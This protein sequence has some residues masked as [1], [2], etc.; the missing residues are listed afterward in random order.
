MRLLWYAGASTGLATG[1]IAYAFNQ[2]ANFYSAMVYLSQNNLSLMILVN[3]VLLVYA[4][5]V[6]GLQRLCY[7]PLRPVEIEQLYEKAWFAV[8]ETCLAMTIFREEVGGWFLVMFTALVTGKVWEWIGEGRV[9]VLEQQPPANPR[10]F[11]LRLSV[12]LLLSVAYDTWLFSYAVH[13]VIQQARPNMMVMFLFEFAILATCSTRTT[14]R[15]LL[16]LIE[17]D[18]T[19]KQTHTRLEERRRLVREQRNDILRR[20]ES[21]DSAEA[22][23]ARQEELPDEDDIDEMDIEVPG[24]ESKGHWILSLDLFTDL[25]KLVIYSVFFAI[26][27]MFYGLPIHIMRDLF[28]T[29]RSFVKRLGALMRYRKALQDMNKYPDATQEDLS[30]EDTCI[31]CREDMRPWDPTAVG[32]VERSRPK[33]LPCGHILH[34]GCLK[35][36]LERQQVCPTCRRSVVID[37]TN[38]DRNA[39]TQAP[40][41]GRQPQPPAPGAPGGGAGA[42]AGGAPG[43][44]NIGQPAQG[45]GNIRVFQFG[46]IRLGFAQGDAQDI[47]DLANQMRQ[48]REG[49]NPPIIP[50]ALPTPTTT[51]PPINLNN[52]QNSIESMQAQLHEISNRIQQEMYALQTTQAELHTLYAL[53]VELNRLRQ[54]QPQAVAGGGSPF[55]QPGV[56]AQFIAQQPH[57]H[58]PNNTMYI[59][60]SPVTRHGGPSYASAI[61][62]GSQDLPEGVSIPPGWSLLPLQRLD[63]QPSQ[64][65]V[66][67]HHNQ[68]TSSYD[69]SHQHA[70][71]A[72]HSARN[73][74]VHNLNGNAGSSTSSTD[75][76]TPV[77]SSDAQGGMDRNPGSS[78][79]QTQTE[80]PN[81]AAPTPLIPQWGG[82][83]QLLFNNPGSSSTTTPPNTR[84]ENTIEA[85]SRAASSSDSDNEGLDK[86]KSKGKAKAATVEDVEEDESD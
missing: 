26:L 17:A 29:A 41:A 47:N 36:W 60:P 33:K 85:A 51:A 63:G 80:P 66:G 22:E 9:E 13:V 62:S 25:I 65:H 12:S 34:F 4:S 75:A 44:G 21:D 55:A 7:G 50:P 74:L 30:R 15:Y 81:V 38:P 28:M 23:A 53:T 69:V 37:G 42:G 10:L 68:T 70:Q 27:M 82:S 39:A 6:W 79:N 3:L 56:N 77:R 54:F 16:S 49:V 72:T 14:C 57:I 78:T 43:P 19:K 71:P 67:S 2:R 48:P 11:H 31:I 46:P 32:A 76:Q 8:T 59:P 1:V 61:P 45:R 20:R 18:I 84:N 86:N 35:G 52:A 40:E 58:F 5:F 24:W 64:Q 83:S 73:D